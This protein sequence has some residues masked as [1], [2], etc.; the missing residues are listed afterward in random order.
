MNNNIKTILRI[1]N[2]K[3]LKIA[4]LN[5]F[6]QAQMQGMEVGSN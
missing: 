5:T 1:G 4:T 6:P 3:G 2:F